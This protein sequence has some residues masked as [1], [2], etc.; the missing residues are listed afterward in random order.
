MFVIGKAV[1]SGEDGFADLGQQDI[2]SKAI[3][4]SIPLHFVA[5]SRYKLVLAHVR[6]RKL[7]RPRNCFQV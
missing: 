4:R 3:A 1:S 7:G 2:P 6:H 5:H